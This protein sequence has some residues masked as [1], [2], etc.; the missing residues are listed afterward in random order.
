MT[1]DSVSNVSNSRL[2]LC[3]QADYRTKLYILIFPLVL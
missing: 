3:Y 1:A 2:P